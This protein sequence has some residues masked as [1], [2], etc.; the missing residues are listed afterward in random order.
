M[1][2]PLQ[3]LC[4]PLSMRSTQAC[5]HTPNAGMYPCTLPWMHPKPPHLHTR[6]HLPAGARTCMLMMQGSNASPSMGSN[7]VK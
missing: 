2:R 5:W 6:P 7:L 1:P 3:L 4:L